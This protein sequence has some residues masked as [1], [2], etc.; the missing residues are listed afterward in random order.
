MQTGA[1]AL[2]DALGFRGIWGRHDPAKVLEN[3]IQTREWMEERIR[4]QFAGQPGYQ[5]QVAFLSDTVAISMALA[6]AKNYEALCT[7]YLCDVVSWILKKTVQSEVRL[8]YRGAIAVGTYDFSAQFLIGQAIDEAAAAHQLSQGAIIWLTPR[9]RDAVK[10][11]LIPSPHNTHLVEF[12]VPLK[13][14]DRFKTYT[15]SP[16]VQTG[17]ED[18]ANALTKDIFS[19]FD[20]PTIDVAVK[21]Q[22]TEDHLRACYQWK[23]YRFP[24]SHVR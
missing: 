1:V 20:V 7:V 19:T 12:N 15:V 13:G 14:G 21:R 18:E 22:A 5:C 3:A 10:E 16:L 2:L 11:W 8:T 9:A 24:E 4:K 23:G 6:P 17:S